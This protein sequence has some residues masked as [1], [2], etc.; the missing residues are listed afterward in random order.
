[1]A[2]LARRVAPHKDSLMLELY[3]SELRRFRMAA[4]IHGIA[5]LL[6]LVALE[7]V[8]DLP[9]ES[10]WTHVVMLMLYMLSGLGLALYQLGTYRQPNRWIWLLHRPIHRA[11]VLAS[12]VLV[13]V[14]LVLLA[15]ALPLFIVLA[16]QAHFTSRVI[17]A[18]HYAGAAFV[19]LSTLS[20][21][22]AG[23]YMMLH[24]SRW[25]FAIMVLPLV[26]TLR[27]ATAATVLGLGVTCCALLLFLLYT[28]F[29]PSR[30][31]G[32][33]VGAVVTNALPLQVC[34]YLALVWGGS[35]LFQLGQM[36]AGVYPLSSDHVP[37]G[38]LT[39]AVRSYPDEAIQ[40]GLAAST[41]PRAAAWRAVLDHDNSVSVGPNV[42]QYAVHDLITNQGRVMF[43]DDANLWTFSHDRMMYRGVN[44]RTRV[45]KGW[46]GAGDHGAA[47]FDAQ[48]TV[49]RDNLKTTYLVN[50]RDL[51][52][53]NAAH[54]TLHRVL[55]ADGAEQLAGGVAVLGDRTFVLTNR[56][57][58]LLAPGAG[59]DEIV[60][61]VRLPLPFG[62][63]ERVD[64]A[65]VTDGTLVSFVYGYRQTDGVAA[66]PQLVYLVDRAGHVQQVARRELS[67]DF[68]L[69]FEHKDWWASP[70]L[71]T[72][73][74]MP[75]AL[76]D[77]GS[78]ADD[79]ASRLA[80]LLRPRPAEAWTAALAACL[81][82]AAGAA[83]WTRRLHAAPRTRLAWCLTCL[84]LG[85]P[86]LLSLMVLRPR[87][88][89]ALR[90]TSAVAAH[91]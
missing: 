45:D 69:L 13:A 63:L 89:A 11:R 2:T 9:S 56:R 12:L 22:L 3:V 57:L 82:S 73:V 62:D 23:G 52:V 85:V 34:F 67:H 28:V 68:P 55:R 54:G 48:P 50:P 10:S 90:P 84:V 5:S 21:W 71:Y 91:G 81:L 47:P 77:N 33:R 87:E 24:R 65:G 70:A 19:A 83:W 39:E 27:M 60:A 30:H 76:I 26:L 78:I 88:Y 61:Q 18:R 32:D 72:L 16:S 53:L 44:R 64:A 46:L 37:R 36:L 74:S 8:A 31:I 25:A 1:M 7:Q 59:G 66:A 86:G 75:D 49:V 43:S 20:A 14:T 58:V 42:R 15:V 79:G 17:D 4:A 41:D 51:H 80:Q 35:M 6:I 40:L 38:G 29:H